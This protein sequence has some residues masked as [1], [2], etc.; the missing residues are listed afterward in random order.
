ME[1]KRMTTKS[2]ILDTATVRRLA[3]EASCCPRTI[4]RVA[5]GERVRGLPF[6]RAKQALEKE[7]FVVPEPMPVAGCPAAE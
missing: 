4:E 5:R 3:V 1:N 7:G 2:K 6:Y